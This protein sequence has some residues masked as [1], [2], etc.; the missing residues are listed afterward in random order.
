M[1]GISQGGRSVYKLESSPANY[2]YYW[3]EHGDW[4]I[5]TDYTSGGR[6]IS[7]VDTS[8]ECPED[9][10]RPWHRSRDGSSCE[11]DGFSGFGA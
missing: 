5:S 8:V 11:E 7:S 4:R 10:Q 3:N 9:E 1:D 2:L 6:G